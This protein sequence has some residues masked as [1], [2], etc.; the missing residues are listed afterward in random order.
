MVG[1]TSEVGNSH[2]IRPKAPRLCAALDAASPRAAHLPVRRA[3]RRGSRCHARCCSAAWP[4]PCAALHGS[5][6]WP[7]ANASGAL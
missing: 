4:A 5:L 1:D 2:S 7:D 6:A 3:A